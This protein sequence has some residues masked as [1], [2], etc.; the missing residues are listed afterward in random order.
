MQ[1]YQNHEK[2]RHYWSATVNLHFES[3]V[4]R[5]QLRQPIRGKVGRSLQEI[6]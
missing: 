6:M 3:S 4:E 1:V 5:D 2:N